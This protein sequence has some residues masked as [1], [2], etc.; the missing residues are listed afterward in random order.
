[1]KPYYVA[2]HYADRLLIESGLNYTI[3]RPG[4]LK[5]EAGSGKVHAGENLEGGPIP[6]E[7]VAKTIL[8]I[9]GEEA[10]KNKSFDLTSG[11]TDIKEA[12]KIL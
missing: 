3:L 10:A 1:M 6:R 2:K 4:L 7:D 9:L 11:D 12:I 5:N 8:E